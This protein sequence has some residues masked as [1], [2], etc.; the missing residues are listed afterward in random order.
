MLSISLGTLAMVVAGH[1]PI[2]PDTGRTGSGLWFSVS[3]KGPPIVLVHGASL[4]SR[5]L[6]PLA[7][8]LAG[9]YRVVLPDLRSHGRSV[10]AIGSF[11]F[12]RDLIEVLDAVG[13]D[14]ATLVGHSLGAEIVLDVA[15]ARPERVDRLVLIAPAVSG[16]PLARPPAGSEAL[17]IALRRGDLA[18]V[19]RALGGMPVMR[20][21]RDTARQAEVR[22]IVADNVRLF[23]AERRWVEP[24]DPPA[25]GRLGELRV[26]IL[27]LLGSAD[28]TESNDAG[29][30]VIEGAPKAVGRWLPGCGHLVPIDCLEDTATAIWG[31][32]EEPA[33]RNQD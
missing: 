18:A 4:D 7:A 13:V 20:L 10:D 27:V 5:T 8:R 14:R 15:L 23:K 17:V 9:R 33:N 30:F 12:G 19:G 11:S 28:P 2:V 25:G 6:E 21:A 1:Q 32:L 29:R 22:S 3:G 24:L 31:F 16:R 26:P